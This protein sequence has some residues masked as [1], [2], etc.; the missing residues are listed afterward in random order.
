MADPVTPQTALQAI[1]DPALDP[2]FWRSDRNDVD[3]AWYGHVAFAHWLVPALRPRCIVEL[4]SHNGVSYAAFCR[5]V[6]RAGL[7]TRCFAVD[8]W[9]GDDHA[10]LYGEEVFAGLRAYHDP[11]FAAF[12]TLIRHRFDDALELFADGS[13]DLLHIDGRHGYDDISH[14]FETW[15]PKLSPAGVVLFHDTCVRTEGFGVWRLWSELSGQYPSFEFLHGHGLGV[16]AP[17]AECPPAVAALA[18]VADPAAMRDRFAFLG[19]R[20]LCEAQVHLLGRIEGEGRARL[21]AVS[22]ELN[23]TA[24]ALH[25]AR[26]EASAAH[27]AAQEAI[28]RAEAA[29]QN[30][31]LAAEDAA[32]LQ[33]RLAAAEAAQ[34]VAA[35]EAAQA[36]QDVAALRQQER[37]HRQAAIAAEIERDRHVRATTETQARTEVLAREAADALAALHAS[38]AAEMARRHEAEATRDIVLSSATWRATGPIRAGLAMVPRGV[39]RPARGAVKTVWRLLTPHLNPLRRNAALAAAQSIEPLALPPPPPLAP[40]LPVPAPAPVPAPQAAPAIPLICYVSGEPDTPGTLYRVER[41][42]EAAREAGAR[43]LV[44]RIDELDGALAASV[45]P[46]I[47]VIWRAVWTDPLAAFVQRVRAEGTKI[48]FDIDDLMIDPALATIDIIDGIRSQNLTE[49]GVQA[50]YAAVQ[51]TMHEADYTVAPTH[52]LAHQM[53]RFGKVAFVLPN[54]FDRHTFQHSRMAARRQQATPGDGL[55]RLGYAS[56]SR[57]H[58]RDFAEVA[59]V[60]PAILR[61]RPE[62]RLVLFQAGP[63]VKLIDLHEFPELAALDHQIEWRDLVKLDRLPDEIARFDVNLAPLQLNNPF[64]AAK[65]ELKFFEGALAGVCTVASPVGPFARAIEHG[66]TGFLAATPAEWTA[67]LSTLLDDP[68]RR[69]QIA[70]AALVSVLWPYGPERRAQ[71]MRR[72]LAQWQGGPAAADAFVAERPRDGRP[73]PV[74]PGTKVMFA[75][76]RLL[77]SSVTVVI[78][79][80]NYAH[81]VVAALDSVHAQ[82]LA[83]LDLVVIEDRSTDASLATVLEWVG[84]HAGRFNRVVVLQNNVNSGVAHARNAAFAVAETPYVLPLDADNTLRPGCCAALL[85]AI[86]ASG[87]AYAYPVIQE[88]GLR[89]GRMGVLPYDPQRFVSGNYIDAMALMTRAAWAAAGGYRP[90]F[91]WEDYDLWCVMAEL[92]L[93]GHGV[94][95][96]PLADYQAHGESMLAQVTDQRAVKDRVIGRIQG[97]HPWITVTRPPEPPRPPA[98]EAA[99]LDRVLPILRCPETGQRLH[100]TEAGLQTEDGSRTWPLKDGRPIL[101]PGMPVD[102][103]AV[104]HHLSN[105]VPE[106]ALALIHA[107]RGRVLNLSA[108]GTAERFDHVIEVEAALF[109]HTDLVGDSHCLPFADESFDVVIA[110]NAFEHYRNPFKA[111]SEIRRVLQPGGRVLIRTAFLQPQH[112]APHHYYNA[113]RHGVAAWFQD[114]ETDLLHV[115]ENFNPAY[116]VAWLAHECRLALRRELGETEAA[117]FAGESLG[118]F[119]DFWADPGTRTHPAWRAFQRL[120]Q[121]SQ[122]VTAAGF[123]YSGRRPL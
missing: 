35:A 66:V 93:F 38:H 122:D 33:T 63:E 24:A 45:Q 89:T 49:P 76:D 11:R 111:A 106:S 108:G 14:D 25:D 9:E 94:P 20:G 1:A 86:E 97:W 4:G 105:E 72:M 60:L 91:G 26:T 57:T 73:A 46:A 51:R 92:G 16:L 59:S 21:H 30:A 107:A 103:V 6:Q 79:I 13:V 116:S 74:I 42:A 71:A 95:G 22:V 34:R 8:T 102:E 2:L 50:H 36:A 53:R 56:G 88:S 5:A 44:L 41:Y 100:L 78:P 69:A 81:T 58:Q 54:G 123:E 23:T 67:A 115:S 83:A 19:E 48:V 82:T 68:A 109:G 40:P 90:C 31:A 117:A 17:G 7:P 87:A 39:R 85:A 65:S 77:A 120:T 27:E 98:P 47:V 110:M 96:E 52:E 37:H 101:F 18:G 121:A 43:V 28:A 84:A 70:Q 61:A 3:S 64:C 29:R 62:C 113:T 32:R 80:Y 99:G 75:S 112:E 104:F 15:R 119:A 12:S 55:V 118:R 10:G 114:F